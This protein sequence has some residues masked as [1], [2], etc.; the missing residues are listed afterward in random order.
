MRQ[1][2]DL[3][4]ANNIKILA[5]S[6]RLITYI[7]GYWQFHSLIRNFLI[8]L[9]ILANLFILFISIKR[10]LIN[11]VLFYFG[12]KM[13]NVSIFEND[14]QFGLHVLSRSILRLGNL[15]FR[16]IEICQVRSPGFEFPLQLSRVPGYGLSSPNYLGVEG[17]CPNQT[18]RWPHIFY[19]MIFWILNLVN[20]LFF[21]FWE[22][23]I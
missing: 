1:K 14:L 17:Q 6:I 12:L 10:W 8:Y 5:L 16:W 21:T 20:L 11:L 18:R 15:N 2:I 4:Q 23:I 3:Y 9:A 13:M 22:D 7:E 19:A